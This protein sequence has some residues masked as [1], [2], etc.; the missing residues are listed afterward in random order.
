MG[1]VF[2]NS[3]DR[4][5]IADESLQYWKSFPAT[6]TLGSTSSGCRQHHHGFVGQRQ[7]NVSLLVPRTVGVQDLDLAH[8]ALLMSVKENVDTTITSHYTLRSRN[9]PLAPLPSHNSPRIFPGPPPSFLAPLLMEKALRL[10]G[11]KAVL[12]SV[13]APSLR[14]DRRW[15]FSMLL[16]EEVSLAE[17]REPLGHLMFD[18]LAR[19]DRED[20]CA[21]RQLQAFVTM[22]W[23]GSHLR[24]ISSRVSCLVSLT[25]QKIMNHAMRL[26]PA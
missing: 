1:H 2:R 11:I 10:H 22:R 18:E 21:R 17:P 14:D 15:P 16:E 24:S 9:S 3:G 8:K 5:Q 6:N 19:W 7:R 12:A 20:L 13:V 23:A 4:R 25:K 26:S